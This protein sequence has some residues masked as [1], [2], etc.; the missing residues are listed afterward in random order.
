MRSTNTL[1]YLFALVIIIQSCGINNRN[2]AKN[3]REEI[4]SEQQQTKGLLKK[5]NTEFK[6]LKVVKDSV[7]RYHEMLNITRP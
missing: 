4:A 6:K 2:K 5:R 1:L 7:N 3:L